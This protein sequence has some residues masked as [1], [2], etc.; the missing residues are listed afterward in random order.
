MA[1]KSNFHNIQR[2]YGS[3]NFNPIGP[4]S[5]FM[6]KQRPGP[7][8][9]MNRAQRPGFMPRYP[10]QAPR[11]MMGRPPNPMMMSGPRGPM[12]PLGP[13]APIDLE[14]KSPEP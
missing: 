12:M 5:G 13:R 7:G 6:P 14:I 11:G 3:S 9:M 8:Y 2:G 10:G 4:P 1:A